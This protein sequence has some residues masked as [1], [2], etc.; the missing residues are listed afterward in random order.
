MKVINKMKWALL[1]LSVVFI[2]AIASSRVDHKQCKI[3]SMEEYER[4]VF[5]IAIESC[6]ERNYDGSGRASEWRKKYGQ[7]CSHEW[8]ILT[9]VLCFWRFDYE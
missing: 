5:G 2:G 9:V 4:S 8:M 6:S 1:I 7:V 3:C